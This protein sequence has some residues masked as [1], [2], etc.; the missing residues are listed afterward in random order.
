VLGGYDHPLTLRQVFYR[1]VG[2]Q[3]YE[4][5]EHAYE[6]LGEIVN[7]ARRAGTIE[8]G[9]IRDDSADPA[10]LPDW[11]DLE[12]F[13][14]YVKDLAEVYR[15]RPSGKIHA[16][17][18]VEATGMVPEVAAVANPYGV[19]VVGSGGFAST[20]AKHDAAVRISVRI[21]TARP[22]ASVLLIGDL[23]P[24][25]E[26]VMDSAAEDVEAFADELADVAID[27][28]RV[29]VTPEQ[30]ETFDLP[31]VHPAATHGSPRRTST[32]RSD[33]GAAH[34]WRPEVSI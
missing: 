28:Q 15:R 1:L 2:T 34:V 11:S 21:D 12:D 18:W 3:Q 17:V 13:L 7:R 33:S 27:F 31:T 32:Q 30:V 23:D 6:R 4:K 26:S 14:D 22:F 16:E 25:G 10:D 24:S 8:M 19:P 9:A 5:S 20:T 29:A